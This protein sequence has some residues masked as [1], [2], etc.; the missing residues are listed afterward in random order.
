MRNVLQYYAG[1]IELTE[2]MNFA[3]VNS[4]GVIDTNDARKILLYSIGQEEN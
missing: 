1:A 3:H 4:D 2:E